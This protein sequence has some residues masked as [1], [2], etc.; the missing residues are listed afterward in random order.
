MKE[1]KNYILVGI[2]T[3]F[4]IYFISPSIFGNRIEIIEADPVKSTVAKKHV[5]YHDTVNKVNKS[6]V[7]IYTKKSIQKN[8]FY[9][10]PKDKILRRKSLIPT[11]QGSGVVVSSQGHIITNFHV[12]ANSDEI[13]VRDYLGK[14][15]A[16]AIIGIDPLT[17]LA[18]LKINHNTSPITFGKIGQV[19]IGDV[20]LAIGNPLGIG[21]TI[22]LGIV[23][24]TDKE[25]G[26]GA[27]SYQRYVQTDA[28][29]NPGNSGGAL[30]NT[31]G[32]LIGI[33]TSIMTQGGGSDG[34][35]FAIPVDTAKYVFSEIIE[36]GEVIRGFIGI[37]ADPYYRGNGILIKG[38]Y[39]NGPGDDAGVKPN[40]IIKKID[41][42]QVQEVKDIQN[43]IGKSKPGDMTSM[44]LQRESD[45]LTVN[46]IIEKMNYGLKE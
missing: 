44:E 46:I 35:G 4:I 41:G 13:L 22:T 45:I 16:T 9:I 38:V 30:V 42:I 19:K 29:I 17:D 3:G 20:S 27:Y 5:S 39:K 36:H 7:S 8:T 15:Y 18:I 11:G 31:N 10:D 43:I 23:S 28:A 37:A 14:D 6:V 1:L 26:P 25:I 32:E 40:D 12:I 33:N 21:Q 24:A 2:L 34:I